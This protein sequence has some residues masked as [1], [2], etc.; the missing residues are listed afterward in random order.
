MRLLI[1][2]IDERKKEENEYNET[3]LRRRLV[4]R[5]GKIKL[6]LEVL[7]NL[8]LL[9]LLPFTKALKFRLIL[10]YVVINLLCGRYRNN[11]RLIWDEVRYLVT[12]YIGVFLIDL[13]M[14]PLLPFSWS[15]FGR[16]FL[17]IVLSA[18][19]V[20]AINRYAHLIFW[21][22]VKENVLIIGTGES[23]ANVYDVCK[24]NRF[25][26]LDVRGFVEFPHME[27]DLPDAVK[28]KVPVYPLKDLENVIKKEKIATVLV[29]APGS[30]S[31]VMK[32]LMR[33]IMKSVDS[34]KYIP[35]LEDQINFASTIDDFDG[36]IM[37][38]TSTGRMTWP[39]K[40][41]KRTVDLLA[42]IP[43]LL[44]LVPMTIFVYFI[45]KKYGNEG[46]IFFTQERIG[47]GGKPIHIYKYR[48][49]VMN[50]DQVLEDLMASDPAIREEYEKNKKL[51]H[52][53]RIIPAWDRLRRKSIDEF[54]QFINVLKGDMSLIGPRPYL[55][56]EKA[57][58]GEIYEEV[59]QSKPGITG[60][61][62]THGRSAVDFERR[63]ELDSYYYHNWSTWLD[64]TLLV[65]TLKEL[66]SKEDNNAV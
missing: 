65:R 9:G 32:S 6:V 38:S 53:P 42:C 49:M 52:D 14:I 60:M 47:K 23:A 58:M 5:I 27:D 25:S 30:G 3:V 44:L 59:I 66:I 17:Y 16:L 50:A 61:W 34:V 20:L 12:A 11:A 8:C 28:K 21:K 40:I 15:F 24:H 43:G 57:D 51:E 55:P 31:K 45:N 48:S 4:T 36:Q 7:W 19:G 26:L 64:L 41:L 56:R 46:P 37:I 13:L 39:E 10:V 2:G 1:S 62:Q 35:I 63:L 29:A 33:R 54:P 22:A 18:L